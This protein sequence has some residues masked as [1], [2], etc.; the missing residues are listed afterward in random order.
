M[1]IFLKF[2]VGILIFGFLLLLSTKVFIEPWVAKK[3]QSLL[4]K[5]DSNNITK[6]GKVHISWI[7]SGL[8]LKNITIRPKS[9]Q[10][11][12]PNLKGEIE[13]LKISGINLINILFKKDIEINELTISKSNFYGKIPFSGKNK[14]PIISPLN[15]RIGKVFFDQIDLEISNTLSA[16]AISVKDGFLKLYEI[17]IKKPDTLSLAIFSQFDFQAVEFSTV[18]A[19][20]MY[21]YQADNIQYSATS[22]TLMLDSFSIQPNYKGYDFTSRSE[23]ETDCIEVDFSSIFMHDFSAADYLKSRSIVSSYIEIRKMNIDVFRDKRR[24]FK[25]TIKPTFQELI[26]DYPGFLNIDS[27]GILAG[28]I[29]YTEHIEEASEPGMIRF[30]NLGAKLYNISNDTLYK[31][32]TAFFELY[33]KARLMGKGNLAISLKSRIFDR[34]NTFSITGNLSEME[35]GE[36]NPMLEKNAFVIVTSGTIESMNFSFSAND[37]KATGKTTVLYHDLYL[38]VKNKQTD[39]TTAFKERLISKIAN[40][41][42]MDSNPIPGNEVRVGI[43]DY[44]RDPERFLFNYCFKSLMTGIKSSLVKNPEKKQR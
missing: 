10:I 9:E 31:R 44:E 37:Q 36:I 25:H 27:I 4:A 38:A 43:I 17:Q 34:N 22:N 28:N 11:A 33:V 19:D 20:S 2:I 12:N 16:Q 5:S 8:E 6:I 24:I 23:Y 1:K 32:D 13:S 39:K 14:K 26:Y 42:V 30:N 7:P 15:I 29:T 35:A 3:I 18:S 21:S 40:I 41:K